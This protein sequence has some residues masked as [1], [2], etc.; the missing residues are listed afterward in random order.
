MSDRNKYYRELRQWYINAGICY[1]C[2]TR[3]VVKGE[4]RCLICKMDNREKMKSEVQK[5]A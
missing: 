1:T 3:P 2:K 5:Y 4:T